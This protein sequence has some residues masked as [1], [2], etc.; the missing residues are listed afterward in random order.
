MSGWREGMRGFVVSF[1]VSY[2]DIY[3]LPEPAFDLSSSSMALRWAAISEARNPTH[4]DRARA[5]GTVW[6]YGVGSWPR[7]I[8]SRKR[9]C[10]A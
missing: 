2:D 7:S 3:E 9:T 4:C 5:A 1:V 10:I 6:L 8:S